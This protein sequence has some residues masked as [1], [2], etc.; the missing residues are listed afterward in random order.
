MAR[1]LLLE[2]LTFLLA[3]PGALDDPAFLS[4]YRRPLSMGRDLSLRLLVHPPA[5]L[6]E[7]PRKDRAAILVA[8]CAEKFRLHLDELESIHSIVERIGAGRGPQ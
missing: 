7:L 5:D 3:H 2:L 8:S 6:A 1:P 4:R